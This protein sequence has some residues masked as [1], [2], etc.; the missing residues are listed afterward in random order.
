MEKIEAL[1]QSHKAA[2]AAPILR[3]AKADQALPQHFGARQID[4]YRVATRRFPA[5]SPRTADPF[6]PLSADD[7]R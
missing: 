5:S 6:S 1:G 7:G 3:R 2:P 4:G